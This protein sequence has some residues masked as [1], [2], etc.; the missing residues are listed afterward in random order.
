MKQLSVLSFISFFF[1]LASCSSNEEPDFPVVMQPAAIQSAAVNATNQTFEYD[2]YGRI[3]YWTTVYNDPTEPSYYSARYSY[4]DKNTIEVSAEELLPNEHRII[5]ES[6]QLEKGR[7]LRSEGTFMAAILT[8]ECNTRMQK[9]YRLVFDYLPTNHLNTV[10]HFEVFGIGDDI[11][12]NAWERPFK[13]ENYL[14]WED[15]NL[16]EFQNFQGNSTPY[17]ST[18]YEYS[19]EAVTYPVVIPMVIKYAHHLPL[20]MQGVFGSNSVNLV[21]S[22]SSFDKNNNLYLT[23]QYSFEIDQARISKYTETTFTN[24]V[25]SNPVTYSV[26]WTDKF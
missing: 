7:A 24:S 10:E 16:K 21:K 6:I 11:R 1:V 25:Y 22:A 14:I 18:K 17:A 15:G 13:W 19:S 12:D 20:T 2:E 23:R 5:K 3:V 8:D 9:T 4:P 26:N